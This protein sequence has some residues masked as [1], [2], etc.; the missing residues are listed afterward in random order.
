MDWLRR[1]RQR[2]KISFS[3]DRYDNKLKEL[4]RSIESL[5]RI[6]KHVERIEDTRR[7]P[8]AASYERVE[9]FRIVQ[10]ASSRLH[11]ALESHWRCDSSDVHY[12]NI[13][14]DALKGNRQDIH[15]D[16]AWNC[17]G[18]A[19][20]WSEAAGPIRLSVEAF[21]EAQIPPSHGPLYS[22]QHEILESVLEKNIDFANIG[23]GSQALLGS[24]QSSSV[25]LEAVAVSVPDLYTIPNLCYHLTRQPITR[26]SSH[27]IGFL[28]KTTTFKHMVY[29]PMNDVPP[30]ATTRT[31]EDALRAAKDSSEGIPLPEKLGLAKLLALA[32]LKYH[33]TPWLNSQW[34]SQDV[35]FFNVRDFSRDPLR[36]PFLQS[37]VLTQAREASGATADHEHTIDR[38]TVAQGKKPMRSHIR[39][40]TLYNLGIM[41]IELAYDSPFKD[42]QTVEDDQGDSLTLH[43]AAERLGESVR[44]V[45]GQRYAEAVKICLHCGFGPSDDLDDLELQQDFFSKVVQKLEKCADAVSI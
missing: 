38:R 32:V 37:S 12:A 1:L 7:A 11:D 24:D 19:G 27:C 36:M 42:L 43:W 26:V 4:E 44:R 28:Q 3:K 14:L 23:T 6:R 9:Y 41:L 34:Q 29:I 40:Q 20:A 18:S 22:G 39:N 16:L 2:S 8:A 21:P 25:T 17:P 15:F 5:H 10:S 45:L 30:V 31:L 35:V 33:S 13:C